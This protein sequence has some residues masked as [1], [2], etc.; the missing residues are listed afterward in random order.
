MN[1]YI[2]FAQ[3]YDAL[4]AD[5]PYDVWA[6]YVKKILDKQFQGR[7]DLLILDLA[8]GTG[9]M[10]L[11]LAK[12]G[13]ELIGVD[14]SYDMLT[15]AQSKAF[16]EDVPIL[17]LAQDMIDLDLYGTIDACI[18]SCDSLNYILEN[19]DLETVFEKVSMFMNPGG[20]FIFDM[21]TEY[22]YKTLLGNRQFIEHL[23]TGEAYVWDNHYDET[24][25][26]NE[27]RVTFHPGDNDAF[28]EHH[29]QRCYTP[30][31]V[32]TLLKTGRFS[33]GHVFKAYTD[34]CL[35]HED[36]RMSFVAIK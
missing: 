34:E 3:M 27:Y 21:K 36:E 10:T 9:N 13:Y 24:K 7:K 32:L 29:L 5:C 30:E 11:R 28:E 8:C 25:K 4:M 23:K 20:V 6:A 22:T 19:D 15:E 26:I 16:D 33:Q 18:C 14:A 35:T 31:E 1:Q 2:G 12:K 17:F